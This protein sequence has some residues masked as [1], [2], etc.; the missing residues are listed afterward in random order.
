[1]WDIKKQK[2]SVFARVDRFSDP[3][4]DCSGI[5]YLPIDTKEAFTTTIAGFE[6][7][8]HPSVR[9]SP[10]FEF[11]KYSD[12]PAGTT[13]PKDDVVARLTFYWVW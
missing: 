10:N 1:V 6:Y 3:C 11:V 5:D 7:Y 4:A 9:F 13:A 2:A 12:P 8:I